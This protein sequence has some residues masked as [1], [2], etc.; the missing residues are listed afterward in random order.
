M[1]EAID[2]RYANLDQEEMNMV[3]A[4]HNGQNFGSVQVLALLEK[5]SAMR[6]ESVSSTVDS[7][8]KM[9]NELLSPDIK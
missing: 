8:M 7:M 2:P 9:A 6:G 5:V 1:A 4:I 3:R